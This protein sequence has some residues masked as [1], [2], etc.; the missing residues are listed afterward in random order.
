MIR[1]LKIARAAGRFILVL[2][3]AEDQWNTRD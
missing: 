2:A 1:F 3:R